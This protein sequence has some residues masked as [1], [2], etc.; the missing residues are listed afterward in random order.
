MDRNKVEVNKNV[1][2]ERGQYPVI[3]TEQAWSIKDLLYGQKITPKNFAF[4]GTKRESPSRQDW[5]I[6]PAREA[7]QN[8][9]F[10]SSCP[11]AQPN[12]PYNKNKYKFYPTIYH[13][14]AVDCVFHTL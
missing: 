7:N 5:P 13:F 8:T 10:A 6:L 11:F 3:L 9:G 14:K 4:A 1:K 2:K 12:Q